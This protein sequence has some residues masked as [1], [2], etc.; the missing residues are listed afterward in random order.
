MADQGRNEE[1]RV[2]AEQCR[3]MVEKEITWDCEIVK[4]Y[5]DE[6]RGVYKNIGEGAK[7]VLSQEKWAIFLEDDNLPEVSFF[8]FCKQDLSVIPILQ[9]KTRG[10]RR[11]ARG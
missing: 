5:A 6:N 1:E 3:R 10:L 4:N 11:I 9:E 7:W 2:Q 8:C